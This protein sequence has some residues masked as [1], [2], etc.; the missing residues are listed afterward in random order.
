VNTRPQRI[1][2]PRLISLLLG[3]FSALLLLALRLNPLLDV[4]LTELEAATY[5]FRVQS[6]PPHPLPPQ[7]MLVGLT[8]FDLDY[9][10]RAIDVRS[11]HF[12]LLQ[13]LTNLGVGSVLFDIVFVDEIT[14]EQVAAFE[15]AESVSADIYHGDDDLA[16]QMALTP[17]YLP[18]VFYINQRYP[19]WEMIQDRRELVER[20]WFLPYDPSMG[21]EFG[22]G[23]EAMEIKVPSPSLV[24][25]AQGLG[26]IN[27]IQDTD[28]V[29]R[30]IPLLVLFSHPTRG[31]GLYPS[32]ALRLVL[33]Q[34]GVDIHDLRVRFGEAI[35]FESGDPPM[36]TRIPINT[37]GEMLINFRE[38]A[39]FT[40]ERSFS[41]E[42]IIRIGEQLMRSMALSPD[43]R[44][45]QFN[46]YSHTID[47]EMFRGATVLV[48][49]IAV[50]S[51]DI[52]ATAI[53]R[54]LP[55]ITVHANVISAI[56]RRDFIT[57]TPRWAESALTILMGLLA[58]FLFGRIGYIRS[59]FTGGVL[60]AGWAGITWAALAWFNLWLPLALPVFTLGIAGFLVLLFHLVHEDKRRHQIR[61]A[62]EAYTSPEVVDEIL[63]NLDD[64]ALWGAK[65]RVTTL[66]VD[67]RGF[68]TM[69]EK[70]PPELVVEIL[71]HYYQVVVDALRRH[72]GIPNKFIGDEV[73]ALFNAPRRIDNPEEAACRAAIDIQLS[74]ERLNAERL[75]PEM[76]REITVGIGVNSGEAIVGIVGRE[77]IEYTA[78][79]DDVNVASRLQGQA[80]PHQVLIGQSTH[81]ALERTAPEFLETAVEQVRLIPE[82]I[83]KGLTRRF[84]VYELCY[85]R[86]A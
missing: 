21:G 66:F 39:T 63:Q 20:D 68:T 31:A 79:G 17:T 11:H 18:Y 45:Q 16:F 64:P 44:P 32:I 77:K 62:F 65:R 76:G 23:Y 59:F 19:D 78:L 51:T 28:G 29:V 14:A 48:G 71:N 47:R 42:T 84:D 49:D 15:G 43:Q 8:D 12:R 46:I 36:T 75:R 22:P 85:E 56:L 4:K 82:I 38:G 33:D 35:E 10:H 86:D 50:A 53:D 81:E 52:R 55:M 9:W 5:D 34:L 67:I 69:T 13:T 2:S 27:V 57:E 80:R 70:T 6:R 41:S 1:A 3:L 58:G 37:H 74:I 7:I 40:E 24:Q 60:I 26:H 83:L 61:A 72:G 30:R 54:A 25:S 73:M